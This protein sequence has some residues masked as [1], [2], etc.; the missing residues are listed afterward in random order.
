[1][2]TTAPEPP[3]RMNEKNNLV[4]KR[5]QGKWTWTKLFL[6]RRRPGARAMAEP[7]SAYFPNFPR[8][9]SQAV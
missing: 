2:A 6:S 4:H 1:M 5:P 8:L 3:P 9:L 7:P